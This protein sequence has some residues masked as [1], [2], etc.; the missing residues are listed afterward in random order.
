MDGR[1]GGWQQGDIQFWGRWVRDA[2]G[3]V[4]LCAGDACIGLLRPA[5]HRECCQALPPYLP[6]MG[7]S[8]PSQAAPVLLHPFHCKALFLLPE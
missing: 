6:Q 2:S 4:T 5:L 7:I 8:P 1:G 3:A